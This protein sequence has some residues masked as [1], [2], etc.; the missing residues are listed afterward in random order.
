[1]S[2]SNP[3]GKRRAFFITA[4]AVA[5]AILATG[6]QAQESTPSEGT[7][8]VAD[9][10]RAKRERQKSTTPKHVITDDDVASKIG[11]ADAADLG[12]S[13]QEVRAEM[14]K[15]YSQPLTKADMM[16]QITEMQG[17][18][19]RGDAGMLT[20][21]KQ[22]ALAGYEAVEFPG[23]K[24]WEHSLSVVATRMVEEANKG[25]T[26]LQA[27]VDGNQNAI[28]GRDPT[29][30]ARTREAWIN[31]LLPYA[32]WQHRARNL[33][34]DG[35]A[36]ATAYATGNPT[37]VAQHRQDA[38][39][40][41]EIAV[42]GVLSELHIPEDQLKRI[43]GHYACDATQWPRDPQFPDLPNQ[44]WAMYVRT[45]SGAGYRLE[46]QGCDSGHYTAVAVPPASDGS[47]GRAFCTDETG[48]VRVSADGD[49][50]TCLSRGSDGG[51]R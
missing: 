51:G 42:A 11:P 35:K 27:I 1:M 36:R 49:P 15:N 14:E 47:Q 4:C 48:A 3:T 24:E 9:A 26:R 41:N 13:E 39:R 38:V 2:G 30:L 5:V 28:A 17:V 6:A 43:W 12:A 46:M 21:F 18:A 22:S 16:R 34:E 45:V 44:I 23:K 7:T 29:A 32:T 8:S 40:R 33:E 37:G 19:A 50:A 20:S 10:A 25:V 31:A